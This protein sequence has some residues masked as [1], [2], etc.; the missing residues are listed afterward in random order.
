MASRRVSILG[1][2]LAW[3]A[4]SAFAQAPAAGPAFEVASIKPSPPVTQAMVASGKMHIGM[5]I[6]AARVDIGRYPLL[7][8]ICEAYKLKSYQVQGPPWLKTEFYDI[9]AKM[10]EGAN[11]DQVP[12]MLQTLLA[13]RFNLKMHRD[14]KEESVY[15]LIVG[16]GG[17]KLKE[18]APPPPPPPAPDTAAGEKAPASTGSNE[19]S[20]KATPG[21]GS[22]VSDGEGRSQKA[23]LIDGGKTIHIEASNIDMPMFAESLSGM[24]GK[25]VVDATEL[26]GKYELVF[27]FSMQELMAI[28]RAQG[29]PVGAAPG[30]SANAAEAASD[31]AGGGSIFTALQ[32]MGL[33]LDSRKMTLDRLIVDSMDKTPTE[34]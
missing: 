32:S 29:A 23:T 18:S 27:D 34:N 33:K 10:P 26:K 31:P 12:Q 8:L 20:V 4:I 28:A 9:V 13:E 14:S 16:K 3:A 1:A 22:Q 11:K 30:D 6:D 2:G 5:K 19:V 24:V 15:A 21:V 17:P 7:K 25:P